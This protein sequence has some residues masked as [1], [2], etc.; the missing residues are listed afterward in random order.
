MCP[1]LKKVDIDIISEDT[2]ALGCGVPQADDA[3]EHQQSERNGHDDERHR[4]HRR[5]DAVDLGADGVR[6][7]RKDCYMQSRVT[8]G[9]E[10]RDVALPRHDVALDDQRGGHQC[11]ADDDRS[12]HDDLSAIVVGRTTVE[13][14]SCG[15][16][17][18]EDVQ[19]VERPERL[20]CLCTPLNHEQHAQSQR[21]GNRQ[22]TN[23]LHV[24]LR[25]HSVVKDHAVRSIIIISYIL[26]MVNIPR[27]LILQDPLPQQIPILPALR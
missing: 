1:S 6:Q 27:R 13:D 11:G 23:E 12:D 24:V 22:K 19:H 4:G 3:D 2:P 16:Q 8:R 10:E 15:E 18:D 17:I 21:S 20:Q 7:R 14:G 26:L 9:H 5:H 25:S